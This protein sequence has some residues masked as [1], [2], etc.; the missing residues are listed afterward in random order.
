MAT[1]GLCL[2]VPPSH[3]R[4]DYRITTINNTLD[5]HRLSGFCNNQTKF[6]TVVVCTH[7]RAKLSQIFDRMEK[8]DKGIN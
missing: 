6:D 4:A 3:R 5:T 2:L 1:T 7:Q 8:I